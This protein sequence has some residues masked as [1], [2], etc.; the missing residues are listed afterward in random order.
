MFHMDKDQ[1]VLQTS[2]M[3][4]DKEELTVTPMEARDNFKLIRGK[5]GSTTSLPFNQKSG[6][7]DKKVG[8][9]RNNSRDRNCLTPKQTEYIY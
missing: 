2:L 1:K 6:G 3:Y 7:N 8:S 5:D 9:V 4:T